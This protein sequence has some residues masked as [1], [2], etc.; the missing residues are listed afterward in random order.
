MLKLLPR[1]ATKRTILLSVLS[2]PSL[3]AELAKVMTTALG[4]VWVTKRFRTDLATERVGD[5]VN[6]IF[7]ETSMLLFSDCHLGPGIGQATVYT[8]CAERGGVLS[9][10]KKGEGL[11]GSKARAAI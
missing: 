11:N 3:E 5:Y 9:V 2:R 4:N 8:Q 7:F 1:A 6:K 10:C